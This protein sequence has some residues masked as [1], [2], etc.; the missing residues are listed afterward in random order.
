MLERAYAKI[1]LT[2]DVLGR[3]PDGYHEVDMVMQTVDL[4]DLVW[5]DETDGDAIEVESSSSQIPADHRNLA[6]VAADVFRRAAGIRRGVRIRIDKSIPVAAGL[7]G[8]SA[9]AAA[10]LRGLNRLWNTGFSADELAQMGA[11]VGSDVP[12]LVQSGCAIARGRGERL[13]RVDHSLRAWVVLIRPPVFVSTAEV[14]EALSPQDYTSEPRSRQLVERLVAG[15]LEQVQALV[16]NGLAD[17]AKRLY[18]EI[19]QV[20]RRVEHL[21]PVP[22]HMS[23]SG[24]TLYCLFAARGP[25]Q[26]LWGAVRGFSRDVYLCRFV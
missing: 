12:F 16:H 1:N 21:S 7:G 8:G 2:L 17:A 11:R 13:E 9:D 14:Y 19:L 3:R 20:E 22:V 5:L 6:Y 24:P 25:A 15:D 10:V 23:G 18:P 4:S 26:R